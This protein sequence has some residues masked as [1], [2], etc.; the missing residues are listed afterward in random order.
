MTPLGLLRAMYMAAVVDDTAVYL[1][2]IFFQVALSPN[3]QTA[4]YDDSPLFDQ[5]LIM[6]PRAD[7]GLGHEF[8]Y[9]F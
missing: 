5:L 7:T 2:L 1:D 8:L 3:W 4:V 6:S 9:S